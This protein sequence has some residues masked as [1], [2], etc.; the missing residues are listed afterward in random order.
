MYPF[1]MCVCV[2][3]DHPFIVNLV[4]AFQDESKLY[5]VMEY[6]AGGEFYSYLRR[7]KRFTNST[8]RF[9][10][11]HVVLIFQYLHSKDSTLSFLVPLPPC[12]ATPAVRY[13][14]YRRCIHRFIPLLFHVMIEKSKFFGT[15]NG[16]SKIILFNAL[17][18]CM[19]YYLFLLL[20]LLKQ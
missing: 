5:L 16:K 17:M 12:N 18:G 4:N 15:K 3:A 2:Y 11:A 9:Y 8:A 6:V 14:R 19:L 7:M 1:G 20:H 13:R 10:A